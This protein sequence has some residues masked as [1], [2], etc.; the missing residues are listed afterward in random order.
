MREDARPTN[1]PGAD[2]RMP[3]FPF[4]VCFGRSGGTLLRAMLCSHPDLAI[5]D[6]SF[7]VAELARAYSISQVAFD[8]DRF[9]AELARRPAFRRW[10]LPEDG[11][12]AALSPAPN[13]YAG[14]VRSLYAYYARAQAKTRY[15]DR[16]NINMF[17]LPTLASTF[18]ESRF[19]HLVRDGRDVF[20]SWRELP[21]GLKRAE[22]VALHWVANV[23]AAR[24]A[25]RWVGKDRY[26]EIHYEHLVHDPEGTLR[27][28]CDFVGL[29]YHPQM[30]NF[31]EHAEEVV[32]S[33]QRPE[34]H[35]SLR[36]ALTG[37][38]RQWR[39]DMGRHDIVAFEALAGDLL[40]EL[41]YELTASPGRAT[42]W[43]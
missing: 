32:E 26:R 43:C 40:A 38:A 19:V 2:E 5:P 35:G 25:G 27:Q 10:G 42:H 23:G 29:A 3:V 17:A 15:G 7:F 14:A 18:P 41:G 8:L 20:L 24:R 37:E 36:R 21:F 16:T 11:L 4:F 12:M 9:L 39:R 31:R 13:D 33:S 34:V 6:E 28:V 30:L 1:V 22:E